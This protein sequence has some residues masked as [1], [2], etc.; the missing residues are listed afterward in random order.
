LYWLRRTA[1]FIRHLPGLERA[2]WLW[3]YLRRPYRQVLAF[4]GRGALVFVGGTAEVR[5]PAEFTGYIWEKF[6][7]EAVAA[8]ANWARQHPGGLVLDV[9]C[10]IGI[11]SAIALFSG[12]EIEVVA[13]DSDLSSLAAVR[14]LCQYATGTRLHLVHGFI[15][16][17]ATEVI[18]L[19]MAVASTEA[20]LTR[21]GDRGDNTRFICLTD[22]EARGLPCRRLDDLLEASTLA[23]RSILIK[24]D[25]EGA[26]LLV[27]SGAE[28]LLRRFH[29][30]ILLSVHPPA[31]PSYG[32]SKGEVE[33]YLHELNYEFHCLAVDH[34]EH[35]W[36]QWKA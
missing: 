6:E 20:A 17:V 25:V 24:C 22:L 2:E 29:P 33:V 14:R 28:T 32:H 30:D 1:Q 26:E 15:A 31:L 11:Y 16:Q 7:P 12:D 36:C 21:T 18:C 35:W 10:S 4:G 13:F 34:E 19:D 8:C 27:L 3:D 23:G 5:I 9:G